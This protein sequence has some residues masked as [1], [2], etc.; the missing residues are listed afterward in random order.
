MGVLQVD[1]MGDTSMEAT[2]D[3]DDFTDDFVREVEAFHLRA[4]RAQ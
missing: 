1:A 2:A 3:P 4:C